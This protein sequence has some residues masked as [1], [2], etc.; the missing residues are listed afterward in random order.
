MTKLQKA[1]IARGLLLVVCWLSG[2][3]FLS[4]PADISGLWTGNLQW[5]DGPAATFT[6]PIA[7]DLLQ[8]DRD[9]SGTVTVDGPGSAPLA[10][11]I[12][13]G[14]ARTASM[15]LEASGTLTTNPPQ[16]VTVEL[17]GD[18]HGSDMSGTGSQ[19]INGTTYHFTWEAVLIVPAIPEA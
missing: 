15:T 13:S 4:P 5:T 1:I 7:L 17:D 18:F 9:L 14:R 3:T 10:L 2:C 12:S 19:T 6:G 8:E 16:T 11:S